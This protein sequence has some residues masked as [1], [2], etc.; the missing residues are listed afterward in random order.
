MENTRRCKTG[1]GVCSSQTL[2][3]HCSSPDGF[4]FYLAGLENVDTWLEAQNITITH[5]RLRLR[6]WFAIMLRSRHRTTDRRAA[7]V[8]V[9]AVDTLCIANQ[10]HS[11]AL[12]QPETIKLSQLP[13]WRGGMDHILFH[14]GD[15]PAGFNPG[16]AIVA[17]SS[18]LTD[19]P[20]KEYASK[21][22]YKGN[23]WQV[24][25]PG[26]DLTFPIPFY[27]CWYGMFEHLTRYWDMEEFLQPA[28]RA[29]HEGVLL[30]L[31][32]RGLNEYMG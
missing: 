10:C 17:K 29:R 2:P 4:R 31:P 19:I 30:A 22:M 12:A 6:E 14:F 21:T 9:A 27:R 25:R 23:R 15:H 26:Y 7:C 3:Q 32:P 16:M 11:A 20:A 8:V 13:G 24:Y 28:V 1:D 18:F 5:Q